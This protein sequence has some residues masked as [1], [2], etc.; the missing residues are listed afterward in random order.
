MRHGR[1]ATLTW[2]KEK[3]ITRHL[4]QQ[5]TTAQG[6]AIS[7]DDD[8]S[9]DSGSNPDAA[10]I[11]H[12]HA[13]TASLQNIRSVVTIILEPSSPDYKRWRDLVLLMLHRYALDD[14]VLSDVVGSSVYWV[15]LDSIVVT[16]ILGTLSPALHEIVQELTETAHHAWHVIDAQF[17]GNNESH[18][19]QLDAKFHALK[20]GDLS[21][22]DNCRRMK[23]M[24]DNFCALGETVTSFLTSLLQSSSSGHSRSPHLTPSATTSNSVRNRTLTLIEREDDTR[25]WGNFLIYFSHSITMSCPPRG[26]GYILIGC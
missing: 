12:L 6:I 21:V 1:A 4:E 7:Q 25:S 11:A 26:W 2:E 24:A 3:T 17:L 16:W 18:V 9:V 14:H 15:R 13:Q 23:G 19:L 22:S 8:R 20:Q 10:L 5:L